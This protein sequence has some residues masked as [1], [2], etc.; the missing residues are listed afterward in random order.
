MWT[1]GIM[2]LAIALYS[3]EQ[4]EEGGI[5]AMMKSSNVSVQTIAASAQIL[6]NIATKLKRGRLVDGIYPIM[7]RISEITFRLN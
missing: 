2:A 5:T 7:P 4:V 1:A 6:Y 3:S